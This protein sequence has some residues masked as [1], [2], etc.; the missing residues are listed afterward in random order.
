MVDGFPVAGLKHLQTLTDCVGVVQHARYS[1]P[2]RRTGYTT[3][4]NAR[5]LIV[6]LKYGRLT[7]CEGS[8]RLANTYLA[9]LMAAQMDGAGFR[10]VAGE[11]GRFL[12]FGGSEDCFGRAVWAC[13]EAQDPAIPEGLRRAARDVL[14]R[15][16]PGVTRLTH[17]RSQAY[18]LAGLCASALQGGAGMSSLV[19]EVVG[20]LAD[21]LRD[22]YASVAR[23]GWYWFEESLT[24]SN[25]SL[26]KAMF[27][28]HRVTGREGYLCV[29]RRTMDFLI[30]CTFHADV[31]FPPG[32]RGWHYCGG[33]KAMFDQQPIEA[34]EMAEA[35]VW[36]Y[37]TTGSRSYLDIARLSLEWFF[38]RNVHGVWVYDEN[39]GGSLDGLTP[40][41][42]NLNQ[43]AES[44]ISFLLGY[45]ALG[46]VERE[47][48][49]VGRRQTGVQT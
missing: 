15:A 2:D 26:P 21:Q 16:L 7:G 41:D 27:L 36:A 49:G 25:A 1:V 37:R 40:L 17:A 30:D 6:A 10:N 13:G 8:V 19:A 48:A 5:A 23:P 43:G 31:F 9:Y 29:A 47:E 3:D 34:G 24:Y 14:L 33:E 28:A 44:T 35:C 42:V 32:N 4:D 12:D 46:E 20:H 18:A 45:L 11:G 39:T 38:G 22:R